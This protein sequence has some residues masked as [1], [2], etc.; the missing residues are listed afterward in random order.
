MPR[1]DEVTVTA[2]NDFEYNDDGTRATRK[3]Y[4][5]GEE[6]QC[7]ADVADRWVEAGLVALS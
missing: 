2:L 1:N 4:K 6:I 7:P 3:Q 5:K